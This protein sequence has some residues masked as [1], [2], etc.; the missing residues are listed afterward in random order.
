MK[1][2]KV[3]VLAATAC[4]LA[5]AA[6]PI[7]VRAK[8]AKP[9]ATPLVHEI[10][11]VGIILEYNATDEDAEIV[12]TMDADLPLAR[13]V[14]L[15]PDRD[16]DGDR[17][18]VLSLSSSNTK[19]LGLKELLVETPEPSLEQ[20][21]ASYPEGRYIFRA[22]TEAG[23]I[24]RGSAV[25]EHDLLDAPEIANPA[26]ESTG[27]PVNGVVAE[28]NAVAGAVAYKL[29]LEQ[30]DLE[31]VLTADVPADATTFAFPTGWLVPNSEYAFGIAAVSEDGNLTVTEIHFVTAP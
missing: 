29:E 16:R 2:T 6:A 11:E 30:E 4:V 28:W 25:L 21:L 20:V 10:E 7:S 17:K 15:S 3:L 14:V 18:P 9:K 27:V 24:A 12:L 19:N 23:D 26:D 13:I 5:I 31:I 8:D 22:R 1:H